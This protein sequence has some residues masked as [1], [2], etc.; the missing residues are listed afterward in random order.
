MTGYNHPKMLQCACPV[1]QD[2]P[3]HN[4]NAILTMKKS[5]LVYVVIQSSDTTSVSLVV[6]VMPFTAKRPS[7]DYSSHLIV[8]CRQPP[9]IYTCFWFSPVILT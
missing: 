2:T 8:T 4:Q 3:R 1:N 7:Q 6:S 5:T 9:P